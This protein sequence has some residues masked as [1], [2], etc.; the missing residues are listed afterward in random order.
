MSCSQFRYLLVFSETI[1]FCKTFL[2]QLI[3]A[4]H[5][6]FF[7]TIFIVISQDIRYLST[8]RTYLSNV[9][10]RKQMSMG[11]QTLW[12]TVIA[13]L[14]DRHGIFKSILGCCKTCKHTCI[15]TSRTS[16]LKGK[17]VFLSPSL[18][19]LPPFADR[20]ILLCASN[21]LIH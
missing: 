1:Q 6:D 15:F 2:K 21:F 8:L 9:E 11:D 16:K 5:T 17:Y 14:M 19:I 3:V 18:S 4:F 10:L 12:I 13:S 20:M 7:C